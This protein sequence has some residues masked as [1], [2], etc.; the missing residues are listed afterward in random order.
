M[1]IF[2]RGGNCRFLLIALACLIFFSS[3]LS[4]NIFA[5]A[6]STC[7]T[8]NYICACDPN[9]QG[10]YE[11]LNGY[12]TIDSCSDGSDQS[13]W[14]YVE[15]MIITNLN[16]TDFTGG[17]RVQVYAQ[18]FC[19]LG[20]RVS[21]A[22]TNYS[23]GASTIWRNI[24]SGT[25]PK[26]NFWDKYLNYTLDVNGGLHAF[27]FIIAYP[28]AAQMTCGG[29]YSSSDTDDIAFYVLAKPDLEY[30]SITAMSPR[31]ENI[32]Y[33]SNLRVPIIVNATDATGVARIWV[34]I[35]WPGTLTYL[36]L[37]YF[38]GNQYN[39]TFS[40]MS[41]ITRYNI[42]IYANDT[43]GNYGT[44]TTYFFL[45]NNN[46]VNI[47][48]PVFSRTY[49]YR[50]ISLNF[51]VIDNN[52]PYQEVYYILNNGDKVYFPENY[53]TNNSIGGAFYYSTNYSN[54]SQ[55]FVSLINY[56]TN[57]INLK[58]KKNSTSLTFAKAQIRADNNGVPS[59]NSLAEGV[60]NSSNMTTSSYDWFNITLNSTISI[61]SGVR[62]WIV[63]NETRTDNFFE[64]EA[65][66]DIYNSGNASIGTNTISDDILFKVF[67]PYSYFYAPFEAQEGSNTIDACALDSLGFLE[68]SYSNFKADTT[69]P[70][71]TSMTPASNPFEIGNPYQFVYITLQDATSTIG[72]VLAEANY[73]NYTTDALGGGSYQY[74]WGISRLG[75]YF[76]R[77]YFNDTV[78]N[79]NNSIMKNFT[80]VD[81]TAPVLSNIIYSPELSS[82]LD[83]NTTIFVNITVADYT[84]I[85]NVTLQYKPLS[86]AIWEEATMHN[87]SSTFIGNFTPDS[88][89]EWYFRIFAEDIY[90]NSGIS[91]Q[92]ELLISYDLTWEYFPEAFTELLAAQGDTVA[93]DEIIINNTGDLL[94]N[95]SI[96]KISGIPLITISNASLLIQN[97]T[98]ASINSTIIAP[99]Q[100]IA[101]YSFSVVISCA[102]ENC[103]EANATLD[104]SIAVGEGGAYV[105]FLD[106]LYDPSVI[107]GQRNVGLNATLKNIG[108][109]TAVNASFYF[110]L[111]EG[112]ETT[113]NVTVDFGNITPYSTT[114][115]TKQHGILA[116][117]G[118]NAT[119]GLVNLSLYVD[120]QTVAGLA[121][122]R[123]LV[124]TIEVSVLEI[125]SDDP[126]DD[127][128]G[129]DGG[130]PPSGG[131]GGAGGGSSGGGGGGG[132]YF[133]ED[134]NLTFVIA[135]TVEILRGENK[136]INF[137]ITNENSIIFE[138]LTF[139]IIG[140]P[141]TKYKILPSFI[142]AL[143]ENESVQ[144]YIQF[145]VPLYMGYSVND[146][147]ISVHGN[148][149][150]RT[151]VIDYFQEHPF[152]LIISETNESEALNCLTLSEEIIREMQDQNIT[153]GKFNSLLSLARDYYKKFDNTKVKELCTQIKEL[154][155]IAIDTQQ[156]LVILSNEITESQKE[157]YDMSNVQSLLMLAN[158]KFLSGDFFEAKSILEKTEESYALQVQ[159]ENAKLGNRLRIFLKN[160]WHY[161]LAALVIFAIFAFIASK[162]IEELKIKNRLAALKNEEKYIHEQ[163]KDLQKKYFVDEKYHQ[164]SYSEKITSHQA[165]LAEIKDEIIRLEA[166]KIKFYK[167]AGS[168]ED[169]TR[170]KDEI[171]NM[172]KSLQTKYFV[173]GSVDKGNYTHTISMYK[174]RLIEIEKNIAIFEQKEK[175][176]QI[177]KDKGKEKWK[178][179]AKVDIKENKETGNNDLHEKPK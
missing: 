98:S 47:T 106:V 72:T 157:G 22:Y 169:L 164:S 104:G 135:D 5:T 27:R 74:R 138:N 2:K 178:D 122:Q 153:I 94:L 36:N 152:I 76:Y 56:S 57:L 91:V 108:N 24:F 148:Y 23:N 78:N 68:C 14:E 13:S 87:I 151:K 77:F 44:N 3:I 1:I 113:G 177:S 155:A 42:T 59:A 8:Q 105:S 92:T 85:S 123:E 53:N 142:D 81:T 102:T 4:Y 95:F 7:A 162:K 40:G 117:V 82:D 67:S 45:T 101:P 51:N 130:S 175:E 64:L 159:S 41:N 140:Y 100:N 173:E 69:P 79:Y 84:I 109:E 139:G 174:K 50:N 149:V 32:E 176:K 144:V 156:R 133:Y 21:I 75:T 168:K 124:K 145:T 166:A 66:S 60:F 12:N 163:V 118:L 19:Y 28:G 37:T 112:W 154:K 170:Q 48:S 134:Y 103:S 83:P 127:G 62:Y 126:P 55:S 172:I 165:R 80:V 70:Y 89:E 26:Y 136:T 16:S 143:K 129:G 119:T 179:G 121:R 90:N 146:L 52:T 63:V 111:P 29:G 34:Q 17:N 120:Y 97:R 107:Q 20:D 86:S 114:F 150:E 9:C 132:G 10:T 39:N 167:I 11:Y 33:V 131:G 46:G 160:N 54:L 158:E 96:A 38:S 43:L 99:E 30:P 161:T 88:E 15:K 93:I 147:K 137:S 71:S 125:E 6:G 18:Y 73:T 65:N 58:I 128:G 35:K 171:T 31:Q 49:P 110:D 141:L 61:S 116:L 25:C 115:L